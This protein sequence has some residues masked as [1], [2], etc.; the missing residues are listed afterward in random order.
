MTLRPSHHVLHPHPSQ[1]PG[2]KADDGAE[3]RAGPAVRPPCQRASGGAQQQAGTAEHG[4]DDD[5]IGGIVEDADV[6]QLYLLFRAA[7]S[8]RFNGAYFKL[9]VEIFTTYSPMIHEQRTNRH[10]RHFE[11]FSYFLL[12]FH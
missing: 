1:Q 5:E 9:S 4:R 8:S 6:G 7:R 3:Q 2:C 10:R 12:V 11:V